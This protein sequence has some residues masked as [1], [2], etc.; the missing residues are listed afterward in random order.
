[1]NNQTTV[2]PVL[3]YTGKGESIWDAHTHQ[4]FAINKDTGD[5]ACDSYHKYMEDIRIM[6]DLGVCKTYLL[7]ALIE[8]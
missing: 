3:L 6:K 4:G 7:V 2:E 8:Y 5:V 1:M